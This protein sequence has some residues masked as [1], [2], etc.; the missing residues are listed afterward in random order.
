MRVISPKVS[1]LCRLEY[2]FLGIEIL[3]LA[4]PYFL[5]RQKNQVTFVLREFGASITKH[6]SQAAAGQGLSRADSMQ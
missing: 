4:E 5:P 3:W 2:N 1:F 6:F